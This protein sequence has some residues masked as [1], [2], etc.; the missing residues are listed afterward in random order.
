MKEDTVERTALRKHNRAETALSLPRHTN[1]MSRRLCHASVPGSSTVPMEI[2]SAAVGFASIVGI[3]NDTVTLFTYI[4]KG[5]SFGTDFQT[6]EIGLRAVGLR[7]THWSKA[8]GIADD[9]SDASLKLSMNINEQELVLAKSLLGRIE[10]MIGEADQKTKQYG[11]DE[12]GEDEVASGK[13][14]AR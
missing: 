11:T 6:N 5:R 1:F 8:I 14:C 3:F 9:V 10:N 7:L 2:A 12:A 4:E 13:F